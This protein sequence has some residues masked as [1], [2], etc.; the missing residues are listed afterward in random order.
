MRSSGLKPLP[1]AFTSGLRLTVPFQIIC[2]IYLLVQISMPLDTAT[3]VGRI[4][5]YGIM[6]GV[7]GINVAHELGHKTNRT[8]QFLLKSY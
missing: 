8:D 4:L 2:G 7:I 3:L 6:C 5:S 1:M